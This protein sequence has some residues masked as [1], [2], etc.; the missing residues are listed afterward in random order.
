[1]PDALSIPDYRLALGQPGWTSDWLQ[2][3]QPMIDAFAEL[4]GDRQFIHVDPERAARTPFGGTVAHGYLTLSLLAQLAG[5]ALPPVAGARMSVNYGFD[6]L[7]FL[8]P[9]RS[10]KRIRARFELRDLR[11][12]A[13]GQFRF[14]WQVEVEIEAE[15]KPALSAEWLTLAVL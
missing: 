12:T 1:M 14:G 5:Q 11:E 7:R 10:G 8:A 6:K 13:A 15:P 4:T 9:V 2:V 3:D